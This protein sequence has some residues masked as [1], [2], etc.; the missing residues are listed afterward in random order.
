MRRE[1][2]PAL[3]RQVTEESISPDFNGT[4]SILRRPHIC[5][6]AFLHVVQEARIFKN[7]EREQ[8]ENQVCAIR[9]VLSATLGG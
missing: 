9:A 2:E 5:V 7:P 1:P 6:A 8:T 4:V 3:P